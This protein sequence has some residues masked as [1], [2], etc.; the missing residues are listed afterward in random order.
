MT[1]EAQ[2]KLIR[3]KKHETN[4]KIA[5]LRD[6]QLQQLCQ[7]NFTHQ[8]QRSSG[9]VA[10]KPE[11]L[12]MTE[13]TAPPTELSQQQQEQSAREAPCKPEQHHLARHYTTDTPSDAQMLRSPGRGEAP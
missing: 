1:K 9:L 13:S 11:M 3:V 10:K 8:Q 4:N 2:K 5:L 6:Q 7:R 12:R